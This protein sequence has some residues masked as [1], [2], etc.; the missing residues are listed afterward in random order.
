MSKG[1]TRGVFYAAL[2][3]A[4]MA[5]AAQPV[6]LGVTSGESMTP[7]LQNGQPYLLDTRAYKSASPRRGEVVVFRRE[8]VTCIKR[9]IAVG[10]DTLLLQQI[11]Y[12]GA[13]E[14][15]ERE[16]V[17]R[18]KR[19]IA[20]PRMRRVVRLHSLTIPRDSVYVVGDARSISRDSRAF[21][22]VPIS[23]ILGRVPAPPAPEYLRLAAQFK[24]HSTL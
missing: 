10:G 12:E 8:G 16:D 13:D 18:I 22:P 17:P 7:T 2:L 9:V 5:Y 20:D 23:C 11:Q 24:S 3:L 19:L 1:K 4:G 21:G 14:L 6:R 15:V